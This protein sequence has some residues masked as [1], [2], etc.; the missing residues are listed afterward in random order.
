MIILTTI[1]LKLLK[2]PFANNPWTSRTYSSSDTSK[3]ITGLLLALKLMQDIKLHFLCLWVCLAGVAQQ[4]INQYLLSWEPCGLE[5]S[6]FH[7]FAQENWP[8]LTISPGIVLSYFY[9]LL[10]TPT[11]KVHKFSQRNVTSTHDHLMYST[12][13]YVCLNNCVSVWWACVLFWSKRPSFKC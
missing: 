2:L 6:R 7:S 13:G 5:W 10:W 3:R 8:C 11:K 1:S 9:L 4:V 12:L